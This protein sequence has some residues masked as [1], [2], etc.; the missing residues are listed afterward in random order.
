MKQYSQNSYDTSCKTSLTKQQCD[1]N[2]FSQ[3]V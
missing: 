3:C 2:R 1:S